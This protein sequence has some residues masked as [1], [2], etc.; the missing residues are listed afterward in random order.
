MA[1]AC[2]ASALLAAPPW[3]LSL[4]RDYHGPPR[5]EVEGSAP[6][7]F[8]EQQ[9]LDHFASNQER[10][11]H[12]VYYLETCVTSPTPWDDPTWPPWDPT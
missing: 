10:G 7:K 1:L 2:L 9:S 11:G 6:A 3:H 12:R 8:Y 5:I 4:G